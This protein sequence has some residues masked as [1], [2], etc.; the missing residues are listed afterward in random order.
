MIFVQH[1]IGRFFQTNCYPTLP[2]SH[3]KSV[4]PVT[5]ASVKQQ[6]HGLLVFLLS[7]AKPISFL[8]VIYLK[9]KFKFLINSC[10]IVAFLEARSEGNLI[11]DFKICVETNP[12]FV[13]V[14]KTEMPKCVF[15]P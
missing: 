11:V 2:G 7:V 6:N 9:R 15:G 3:F 1:C 12:S 14:W 5:S 10:C 8:D 13:C 4:A